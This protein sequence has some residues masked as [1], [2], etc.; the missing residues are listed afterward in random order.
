MIDDT[1][2]CG[3]PRRSNVLGAWDDVLGTV[4]RNGE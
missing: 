1:I 3:K 2:D 4:N